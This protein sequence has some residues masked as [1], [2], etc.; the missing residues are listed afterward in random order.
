MSDTGIVDEFVTLAAQA[1][2]A[3]VSAMATDAWQGVRDTVA[4]LFHTSRRR[5]VA[6]R[7]RLDAD[8]SVLA[9]ASESPSAPARE[10]ARAS[11]LDA[12]TREL[13]S[14][15]H[16]DPSRRAPLAG[17][18]AVYGD[19]PTR[20]AREGNRTLM[21]REESTRLAAVGGEALVRAMPTPSWPTARDQAL[22][23]FGRVAPDRIE[24]YR[25]W[26]DG[27]VAELRDAEPADLEDVR[28]E[29]TALWR[30]QLAELLVGHPAEAGELRR[31]IDRFSAVPSDERS[32]GKTMT[33]IARDRST[34]FAVMDGGIHQHY[35]S[36]NDSGADNDNDRDEGG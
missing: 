16:Q 5:R 26:L 20:Q 10:A 4:E 21:T 6:L 31:F 36:D 12:W 17:L 29:L 32:G 18:V 25:S 35:G 9:L 15:L 2:A 33:N 19:A 14:L 3:V 7:A 13:A 1:A 24:L 28:R 22:T 23:W 34:L 11:L 30:R 8:A 27:N